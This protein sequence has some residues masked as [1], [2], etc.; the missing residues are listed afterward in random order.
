MSSC[1]ISPTP[2]VTES[3]VLCLEPSLSATCAARISTRPGLRERCRRGQRLPALRL[4]ELSPELGKIPPHRSDAGTLLLADA[5]GAART[6]FVTDVDGVFSADPKGPDGAGSEV[7]PRVSAAELLDK[8]F[9]LLP[10]DP[11]AL[12]LMVRTKHVKKIQIVNGLVPG[13]ITRA[14]RG[15]HVGT[16]VDAV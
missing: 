1:L 16:F 11:I 6:I 14:L 8:G 13:T 12:R 15:E 7:L 3:G 9:D 10:V 2:S 4:Y 5:Y